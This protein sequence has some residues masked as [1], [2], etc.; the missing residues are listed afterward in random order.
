MSDRLLFKKIVD[1]NFDRVL[2]AFCCSPLSERMIGFGLMLEKYYLYYGE[3]RKYTK[4]EGEIRKRL[5]WDR[6]WIKK[7]HKYLKTKFSF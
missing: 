2:D 3:F 6:I 5:I 4:K 7:T 1:E